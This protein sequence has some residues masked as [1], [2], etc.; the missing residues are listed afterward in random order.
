MTRFYD[1]RD[2]ADQERVEKILRK[3][4]V[5]YFLRESEVDGHMK[6]IHVAEEDVQ[7]A[8]ELLQQTHS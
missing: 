4:G 2:E 6:E 5:E 1:P 8:E 3:G 7:W